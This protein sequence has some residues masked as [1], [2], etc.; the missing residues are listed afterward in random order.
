VT[1]YKYSGRTAAGGFKKGIVDAET[2][3]AAIAKLRRQGI[4][5]REIEESKS[6]LHKQIS[7]GAQVKNEDFVV[8][9][10]QFATLIRAGISIVEATQILADQTTSKVLK[11]A[12]FTV[13][14][15]IR[16]GTPFSSA[17]G[18]HE[19]VFP[20][21]FVNMIQA[22]E[23]TGNL[24]ETL[25]NPQIPDKYFDN[26]LFL[27]ECKTREELYSEAFIRNGKT[28]KKRMGIVKSTKESI[29]NLFNIEHD[30][31]LE[32]FKIVE[33]FQNQFHFYF[34][35]NQWLINSSADQ[36]VLFLEKLP[37]ITCDSCPQFL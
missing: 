14:E 10:R 33:Y 22:G 30:K 26:I 19:K 29:D 8:Y 16:T 23:A 34:R 35:R 31:K 4:N 28:I 6:I 21:L 27:F 5:P 15:D 11:Q 18:K 1:I 24:D 2:E 32:L 7:F 17:A 9:C 20:P 25:E 37:D 36:H 12:L 13:E 3:K